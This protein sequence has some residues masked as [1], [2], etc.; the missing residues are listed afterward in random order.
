M[1]RGT[2]VS[3]GADGLYKLRLDYGDAKR[4]A[5]LAKI[6]DRKDTLKELVIDLEGRIVSQRAV[7]DAANTVVS[8]AINELNIQSIIPGTTKEQ[9]DAL[10]NAITTAL[11]EYSREL[12]VLQDLEDKKNA[13]N[14]EI[15]S[16]VARGRFLKSLPIVSDVNAWCAD[17]TEN[18]TGQVATI[19]IPG[20]PDRVL[21]APSAPAPT[22]S[23]GQVLMR[24][25]MTPEQA[26]YNAALLPGWQKW[27]PTYRTGVIEDKLNDICIVNLDDAKSSAKNLPINQSTRLVNVPI[28]YL[29]CNGAA[30]EVGDK[31]VVK[32]ESQDWDNPKVIGFVDNPKACGVISFTG[33]II[34]YGV[35]G[36]VQGIIGEDPDYEFYDAYYYYDL[37]I[38]FD[39]AV[40]V[41]TSNRVT[42]D[43]SAYM[44]FENET[45]GQITP[46]ITVGD[47]IISKAFSKQIY[48]PDQE[49]ELRL[50]PEVY[51]ITE[52]DSLSINTSTF[53]KKDEPSSSSSILDCGKLILRT[54]IQMKAWS[55]S[56]VNQ[57]LYKNWKVKLGLGSQ[58]IFD[59]EIQT[60]DGV[61]GQNPA[62]FGLTKCSYTLQEV[63]DAGFMYAV[64]S[65]GY[66]MEVV[67][68]KWAGVGIEIP[69]E[70]TW[71]QQA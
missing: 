43:E 48:G 69:E 2:I 24:Q 32:F 22:A 30:F 9:L 27:K 17:L 61:F 52:N 26:F 7:A 66:E 64:D 11:A 37:Q 50:D 13:A 67:D 63:N 55:A 16:L 40:P 20:E 15:K 38:G 5:I 33:F 71:I 51:T 25:L 58:V 47:P 35:P 21:I 56:A 10:Q 14:L 3:G 41:S 36:A 19:E 65:P 6:D 39:L 54:R 44:V 42:I 68:F 12:K 4:T 34:N 70:V 57:N 28:Q 62:N 8:D 23:D 53:F 60:S 45:W 18:A 31:V 59:G 29:D 46:D 1:G 49:F